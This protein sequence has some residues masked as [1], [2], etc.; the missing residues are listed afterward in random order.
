MTIFINEDKLNGKKKWPAISAKVV[1]DLTRI[2]NNGDYGDHSIQPPINPLSKTVFK[3]QVSSLL[4][5]HRKSATYKFLLE[6]EIFDI[7]FSKTEV[8]DYCFLFRFRNGKQSMV[9]VFNPKPV[10]HLRFYDGLMSAIQKLVKH[11][12]VTEIPTK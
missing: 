7:K 5:L 4:Q 6:A 8:H 10:H 11:E 3:D 1:E 12:D 9:N 2:L